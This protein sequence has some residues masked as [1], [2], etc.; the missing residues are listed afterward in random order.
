MA[1]EV[2]KCGDRYHVSVSPPQG[3]NW[4]SREPL[5]AT[6]ILAA[7]QSF[8]CHSTDISDALHAA[9]TNWNV[10]HDEDVERRRNIH[11]IPPDRS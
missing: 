3:P 9:D 8:G 2:T 4:P 10:R 5:T 6:E 1:I 11:G 7:C